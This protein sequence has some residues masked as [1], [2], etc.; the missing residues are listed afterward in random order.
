MVA[1]KILSTRERLPPSWPVHG[2]TGYNFLNDLNGIFIDAAQARRVRRVYA[3]LTGS[4]EPFDDVLY[5]AK[6]LI[7][8]T[9]MASELN[10]LAHMLDRI[11]E[12]NR[13][14]RDFTLESL[15]DV[16][17]EVVAC[18][19]VYRTYVDERRLDSRGPRG[20]RA[21]DHH[22][23]AAGTRRWSRRCSTSSAKSCCRAILTMRPPPAP[24]GTGGTGT[25]RRTRTRRGSG[26]ASR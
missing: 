15:R 7:M 4:S 12:S 20:R 14:S 18:F 5:D 17:R 6:Q 16:I 21:G 13:K 24:V 25:R 11:G 10:V 8:R 26:S 2:T 19:P 23:R 1:E 9:A 3:K 22:A